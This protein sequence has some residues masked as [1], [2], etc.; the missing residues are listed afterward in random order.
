MAITSGINHPR[1]APVRADLDRIHDW[2]TTA[3][4]RIATPGMATHR[5]T[6]DHAQRDCQRGAPHARG[7]RE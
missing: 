1:T 5:G 2:L 4:P 7:D 6:L 3:P